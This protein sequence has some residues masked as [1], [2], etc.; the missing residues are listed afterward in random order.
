MIWDLKSAHNVATE[1]Y[2]MDCCYDGL[3]VNKYVK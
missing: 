2:E 3:I 1:T